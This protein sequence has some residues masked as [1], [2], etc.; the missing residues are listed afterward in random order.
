MLTVSPAP[1]RT[2]ILNYNFAVDCKECNFIFMNITKFE[3]FPYREII[4]DI[5]NYT[6]NVKNKIDNA[7]EE[8]AKLG[9][10]Y[11]EEHSPVKKSDGKRI[12]SKD[13][14][15]P[16]TYKKK[17]RVSYNYKDNGRVIGTFYNT[18]KVYTHYDKS[19]KIPLSPLLELGHEAK[20]PIKH[21]KT[22]RKRRKSNAKT[23]VDPAPKG[24]HIQRAEDI[25]RAELDKRIKK[26][27]DK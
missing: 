17:W 21:R 3:N 14:L 5:K 6:D 11:A 9:M 19:Y 27:L 18:T 7:V 13:V 2:K 12:V 22:S 20:N 24:G 8:C 15:K 10:K 16:G 23:F 26:I 25:A 1:R 4:Q